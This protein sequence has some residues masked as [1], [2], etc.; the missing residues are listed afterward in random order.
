MDAVRWSC[1][2]ATR[3]K[4]G[5]THRKTVIGALAGT[6]RE[7]A[8]LLV[9]L[10]EVDHLELAT[11]VRAVLTSLSALIASVVVD[12]QPGRASPVAGTD[13]VPGRRQGSS[14]GAT[15]RRCLRWNARDVDLV[16][17]PLAL[18]LVLG[19]LT[20]PTTCRCG[21]DLPHQHGLF[22]LPMHHHGSTSP[23]TARSA[24]DVGD[25]EGP[26]LRAP[27][28]RAADSQPSMAALQLVISL[29]L[30]CAAAPCVPFSLMPSGVVVVPDPPPPRA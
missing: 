6:L 21:A 30:R 9:F 11:R 16:R 22:E 8:V 7:D 4:G 15:L 2:A 20:F 3:S 27:G 17:L 29:L 18:V 1:S 28:A 14:A 26:V 5:V 19:L 12:Q 10:A 13:G 23:V 24:G 25:G